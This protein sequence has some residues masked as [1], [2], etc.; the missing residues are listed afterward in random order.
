MRSKHSTISFLSLIISARMLNLRWTIWVSIDDDI[1]VIAPYTN[2]DLLF[3]NLEKWS[4]EH[5]QTA[6]AT[7]EEFTDFYVLIS[8]LD[9]FV[10]SYN[11]SENKIWFFFSILFFPKIATNWFV[12]KNIES[13]V[14][15]RYAIS[16]SNLSLRFVSLIVFW[17]LQF[18]KFFDFHL[19]DAFWIFYI[20]KI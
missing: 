11:V 3:D 18:K 9:N 4:H 5:D 12:L 17:F 6:T 7:S 14:S 19:G 10:V 8:L 2:I 20:C 13:L 15:F 16:I 1:L